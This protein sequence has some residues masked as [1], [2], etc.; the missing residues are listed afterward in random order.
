MWVTDRVQAVS[1]FLKKFHGNCEC[2]VGGA[3]L[4]TASSVGVG[5]RLLTPALLAAVLSQSLS[6][7]DVC[8]AFFPQFSRKRETARSLG[9]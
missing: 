4:G 5:K 7:S 3:M 9:N 8:F 6:H 2:D 1:L